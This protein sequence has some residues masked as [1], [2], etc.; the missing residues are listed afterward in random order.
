MRSIMN[1]NLTL[2]EVYRSKYKNYAVY[3]FEYLINEH[4][5]KL[6]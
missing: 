2:K 6:K 5:P 1:A 3:R 4:H